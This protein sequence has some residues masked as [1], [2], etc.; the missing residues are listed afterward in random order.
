M[1]NKKLIHSQILI[2]VKNRI[3]NLKL[4]L[5]EMFDAAS[6]NDVKNSAGDKH[7]TGVAMAQL[8]QEKLTKQ[9]NELLKLQE[10][11]QKINPTITQSKIGV[12][13]LVETNN[14]WYYFSVGIGTVTVEDNVIFAIN[15]K[16]PIGELLIGKTKGDKV[17]FNGKTTEILIVQ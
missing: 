5:G 16:A 17:Q 10:S 9:I 2:E 11:L 1:P 14:G 15:P 13:S 7:E 4:I 3:N 12:G 6:G 8:E